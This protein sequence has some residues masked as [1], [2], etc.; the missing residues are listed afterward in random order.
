MKQELINIFVPYHVA[1]L[2]FEK[3]FTEWCAGINNKKN[4]IVSN[5]ES[6]DFDFDYNYL[7]DD[8][9]GEYG[10]PTHLQLIVWLKDKHNIDVT[11][12]INGFWRVIDAFGNHVYF[13]NETE[14]E[15]NQALEVSLNLLPNYEHDKQEYL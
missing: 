5:C 4:E 14:F 1:K 8:S 3:G 7:S 11:M 13:E 6:D 12:Q 2:S 10:I 15:I 9:F